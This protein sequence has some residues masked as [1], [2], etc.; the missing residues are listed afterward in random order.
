MWIMKIALLLPLRLPRGTNRATR[1]FRWTQRPRHEVGLQFGSPVGAMNASARFVRRPSPDMAADHA[2]PER[3]LE[4]P[5]FI[6]PVS[7]ISNGFAQV[8]RALPRGPDHAPSGVGVCM[9]VAC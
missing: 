5:L 3:R 6:D 1:Q 7:H 8:R 2:P 9:K 4:E